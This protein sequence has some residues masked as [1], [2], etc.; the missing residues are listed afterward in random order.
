MFQISTHGRHHRAYTGQIWAWLTN[1]WAGSMG[2]IM[3]WA[4]HW[5]VS[6]LVAWTLSWFGHGYTAI[7]WAGSMNFV[8][9]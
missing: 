2:D 5:P 7:G 4:W 3:V 8:M 9:V 6:G 1:E